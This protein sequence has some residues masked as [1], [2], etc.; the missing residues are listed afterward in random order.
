MVNQ[1]VP[2]RI[3]AKASGVVGYGGHEFKRYP[4]KPSQAV[5]TKPHKPHGVLRNGINRVYTAG[6][7]ALLPRDMGKARLT[8]GNCRLCRTGG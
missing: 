5:T 7:R 6:V 4:I 1:H 2:H 8:Q 3:G